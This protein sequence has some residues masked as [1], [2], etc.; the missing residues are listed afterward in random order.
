MKRMTQALAITLALFPAAQ[1]LAEA[2]A[3]DVRKT[4]GC[5][6]C[7][8]WMNHLEENGFAPK[9]ENMFGGALVRFKLDNGVPQ[10]MVSCH[11]ALID[12]YVIEGHVP[13]ADIRRLREE[14]PDAVGLAVP[15]MPYG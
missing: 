7:L 12:G 2:T 4:N 15:G 10:R 13:A 8:S 3:I 5:G 6:C 9:G 11:T 1:A 14:R